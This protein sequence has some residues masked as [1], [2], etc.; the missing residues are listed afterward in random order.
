LPTKLPKDDSV[1][2]NAQ[3][4]GWSMT[5]S[6]LNGESEKAKVADETNERLREAGFPETAIT[7]WWMLLVDPKI[8]KTA[9]RV[10]ESGDFATLSDLV[11]RTLR[12]KAQYRSAIQELASKHWAEQLEQRQDVQ[13]RLL[14]AE[15]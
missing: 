12:N 3:V 11:D 4:G 5:V 9:H 13:N 1:E 14:G 8:K 2:E 15:H 7:T 10:W 6:D